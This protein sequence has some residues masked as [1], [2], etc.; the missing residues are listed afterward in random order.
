MLR[1]GRAAT[2]LL[3]AI[4]G[5]ASASDAMSQTPKHGGIFRHAIEGEPPS[6]DCHAV[7][8]SFALQALA[9]HYST[10]LKYDQDDFSK[11]VGD[12]AESWTV[13]LDRLTYTFKLRPGVKFHNGSEL[14]SADI[15][16]TF[17]R[18][19]NPPKGVTSARRGQFGSIESIET[20][21]ADT[22]VFK[23]N[24]VNPAALFM[25][26]SPWNCVYSAKKLEAD[27]NWYATNVMG[28]GPFV[29]EEHVK[30]SHWSAKRFDQYFVP[31]KPYLDG[32]RAYFMSGSAT[33]NGL[34]GGQIDGILYMVVAPEQARLRKLKKDEVKLDTN[35]F[36]VTLFLTVNTK[37][38]PFND[39]RV[40]RL[41][42]SATSRKRKWRRF[43]VSG[44]ISK[45]V[46]PR[47]GSFS[48]KP[49]CR[50]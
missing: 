28:T 9:P 14:T 40:R 11:I 30:G 7:A 4:I 18:L 42:V 26:A 44:R 6:Y 17:D 13:S 49:A 5:L 3:T 20:P 8:T 34:A 38:P 23:L 50:T 27:P 24:R 25:F 22:V 46:G 10:L 1:I 2:F 15:K 37:M 19:R 29:F 39:P 12:L 43:P 41:A 35:V 16:A 33:V 36:N 21:A 32:I 47:R 31:G 48:P 45:R